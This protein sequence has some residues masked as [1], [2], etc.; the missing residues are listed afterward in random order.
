M[1]AKR[2]K[3][4]RDTFQTDHG[5]CTM[6][7]DGWVCGYF[8]VDERLYDLHIIGGTCVH[9]PWVVTHLPTG[10]EVCYAVSRRYAQNIANRV[11]RVGDWS[12]TDSEDVPVGGAAIVREYVARGVA[13]H[14]AFR[15]GLP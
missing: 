14:E 9:D 6:T 3:W 2:P 15:D 4:T 5:T 13:A 7:R 8:G 11:A 12:V 1:N 10:Y